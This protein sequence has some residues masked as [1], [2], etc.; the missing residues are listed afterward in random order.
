MNITTALE[1]I[2]RLLQDIIRRL[3]DLEHH[4][5]EV[6]RVLRPYGDGYRDRRRRR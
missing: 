2:L 3:D 6:D 5:D 1:T 4:V